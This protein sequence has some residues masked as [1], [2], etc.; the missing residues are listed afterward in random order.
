MTPSFSVLLVDLL[1]ETCVCSCR[2]LL[3]TD[4]KPQAVKG[5]YKVRLIPPL[6]A[7]DM[8]CFAASYWL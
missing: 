6:P 5:C 4:S 7:T 8:S 1:V 2:Q 3:T